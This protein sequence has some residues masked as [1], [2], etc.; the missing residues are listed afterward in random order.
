MEALIKKFKKFGTLELM[1]KVEKLSGDDKLAC[2]EVLKQRNQDVSKWENKVG[3]TESFTEEFTLEST[4]EKV[5]EDFVGADTASGDDQSGSIKVKTNRDNLIEEVDK[6]IDE[7]IASK[8]TGVYMQVMK[9]LGGHYNSDVEELFKNATEEQLKD[10]L[11]FRGVKQEEKV[12][13]KKVE[14]KTPDTKKEKPEPKEKKVKSEKQFNSKE[15]ENL[16]IGTLV[17]FKSSARSKV[18]NEILKGVVVKFD[19]DKVD[20]EF[21]QVKS[22]DNFFWKTSKSVKLV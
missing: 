9:S 4:E 7:L 1:K 11:T 22:G 10:A 12:A 13:D 15:I 8:R 16:C 14:K 3:A 19:Y 6:F 20:T 18:P 5:Q 2:I 21:V 17:E